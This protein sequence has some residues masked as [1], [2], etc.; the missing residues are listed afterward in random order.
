MKKEIFIYH[1][2]SANQ[3][4]KISRVLAESI[5]KK[6]FSKKAL[7]LGLTGDLGSGKTTF[8]QGFLA[9]LD[10]KRK[11]T[12]PTFVLMKK[13][14]LPSTKYKTQD[15]R[16]NYTYHLDCYR[17]GK[18]NDLSTLGLKEIFNNPQ[19]IVLIEWPEN[20]KRIMPKQTIWIKFKHLDKNKRE[21]KIGL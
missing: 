3:T 13:Y 19:N 11:I 6:T 1:T 8:A 10:V 14:K 17:I 21:I 12:S 16:Y 2:N 18:P 9:G 5:S 4:K 15:T 20:I 7:V